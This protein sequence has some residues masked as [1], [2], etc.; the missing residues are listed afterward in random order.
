MP[1]D[2]AAKY[3]EKTKG[4]QHTV[5]MRRQIDDLTNEIDKVREKNRQ[6]QNEVRWAT[7]I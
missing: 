2:T 7:I 1:R 3:V 4:R 5:E 6:L